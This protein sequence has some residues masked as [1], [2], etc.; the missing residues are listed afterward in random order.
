MTHVS[1]L[2]TSLSVAYRNTLDSSPSRSS[3]CCPLATGAS[4]LASTL[5]AT[6]CARLSLP[7]I[8]PQSDTAT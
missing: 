2:P 5:M 7:C 3:T 6:G 1:W 4:A 8:P